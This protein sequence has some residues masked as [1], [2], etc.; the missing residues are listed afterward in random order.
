MF[1]FLFKLP[2]RNKRL[3]LCFFHYP[4]NDYLIFIHSIDPTVFSNLLLTE[5]DTSVYST[6]NIYLLRHINV[7]MKPLSLITESYRG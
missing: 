4:F 5:N 1:H 6:S 3:R 2:L 7:I